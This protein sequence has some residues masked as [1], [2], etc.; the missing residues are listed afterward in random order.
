MIMVIEYIIDLKIIKNQ[1]S[2]IVKQIQIK[3][4]LQNGIQQQ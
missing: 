3:L 4:T 2:G 1:Q